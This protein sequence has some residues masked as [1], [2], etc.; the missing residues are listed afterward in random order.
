MNSR[1]NPKESVVQQFSKKE[2]SIP[3]QANQTNILGEQSINSFFNS[4]EFQNRAS[5]VPRQNS[6]NRFGFDLIQEET[7]SQTLK[8]TTRKGTRL[9][10][11]GD[12]ILEDSREG[13]DALSVKSARNLR[14]IKKPTFKDMVKKQ[15]SLPD[16]LN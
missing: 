12:Y 16:K 3:E 14:L 2:S 11:G 13:T 5:Y 7:Y 10:D 8:S 9:T 15:E 6:D 1:E 4:P